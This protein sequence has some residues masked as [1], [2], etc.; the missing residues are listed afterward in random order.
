MNNLNLHIGGIE[1][2]NG[3][4]IL[5]IQPHENVDFI[6]DISNLNQ[7]DDNSVNNIYASHVFEHVKS[8]E[9]E[10]TLKGL[11]RVLKPDGKLFLAVP[12]LEI[13]FK[14]YL[15]PDLSLSD[16]LFITRIIY[17]GQTDEYDF[18]YFGWNYKLLEYFLKK[19]GFKQILRVTKFNMFN[20]TSNLEL[21]GHNISLNLIVIK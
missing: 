21:H 13:L 16:K 8:N 14:L 20:D 18:H 6:G 11:Y 10:N 4:K 12:N 7:F 3:W 9:I 19:H 17:G 5:N 15:I 1:K 2:K